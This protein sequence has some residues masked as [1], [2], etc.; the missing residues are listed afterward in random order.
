MAECHRSSSAQ[1]CRALHHTFTTPPQP[2]WSSYCKILFVQSPSRMTLMIFY[3]LC[4]FVGLQ[5]MGH[6]DW[7]TCDTFG[8]EEII[9]FEIIF[10]MGAV[11]V[12]EMSFEEQMCVKNAILNTDFS[13]FVSLVSVCRLA[14]YVYEYLLHVGAQKSAQTFL[15]EVRRSFS[16]TSCAWGRV[17]FPLYCTTT[18][19]IHIT[20]CS[21][22]CWAIWLKADNIN[23]LMSQDLLN[24]CNVLLTVC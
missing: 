16:L 5:L 1:R 18:D 11:F 19:G 22:S 9:N 17:W 10:R 4:T 21:G 13:L 12:G 8:D 7:N 3:Q 14:L 6:L 24:N 20:S 2:I 15:S 23:T